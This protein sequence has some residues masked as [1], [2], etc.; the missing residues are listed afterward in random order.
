MSSRADRGTRAL[1]GVAAAAVAT[2][3][4]T[5]S[6]AA[7]TGQAPP[8]ANL[9]L[10]LGL[11][12]PICVILTGQAPSWWRISIA[13]AASQ[14]LFHS[15]LSLDL[16]GTGGD[17]AGHHGMTM[18]EHASTATAA[19]PALLHGVDSP[20]M[21]LAHAVAAVLTILALGR[22]ERALRVVRDFLAEA[23]RALAPLR[24]PG[25]HTV[26]QPAVPAPLVRS[27]IAVLSVMRRRGPPAVA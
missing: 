26:P 9:L 6:H 1:R 22:G 2:F 19:G 20:W 12:A 23:F 17:A 14:T 21:W 3:A 4:A 24:A 25:V 8:L 13:V 16:A 10:A 7:V 5:A 15:I 18:S 27:G 11:A